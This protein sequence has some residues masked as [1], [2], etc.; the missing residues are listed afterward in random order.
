MTI[1]TH[2]PWLASATLDET[3]DTAV[4]PDAAAEEISRALRQGLI[5]G[6]WKFHAR[7]AVAN[8]I[9]SGIIHTTPPEAQAR[10]EAL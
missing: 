6:D 3:E 9:A 10:R 5:D 1:P 2:N 4:D 7:R 8:G